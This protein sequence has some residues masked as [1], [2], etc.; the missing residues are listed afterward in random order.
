M[1]EICCN[2]MGMAIEGGYIIYRPI[3]YTPDK[4]VIFLTPILALPNCPNLLLDFC[5]WCKANVRGAE[6]E[7]AKESEAT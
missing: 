6:L 5:P 4:Q 1:D 7:Q 2:A 3:S